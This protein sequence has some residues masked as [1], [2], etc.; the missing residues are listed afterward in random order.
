MEARLV[1]T[2]G[3]GERRS[4]EVSHEA[5]IRHWERLRIWI[6]ENRENLRIRDFPSRK[7]ERLPILAAQA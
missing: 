5:L 3:A 7:P 4:V 1:V 6:D 2:D